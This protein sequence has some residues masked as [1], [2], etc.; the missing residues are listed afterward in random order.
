MHVIGDGLYSA[1]DLDLQPKILLF[2]SD[3]GVL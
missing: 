1:I 3:N 2:E